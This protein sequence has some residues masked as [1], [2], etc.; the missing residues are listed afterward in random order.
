MK[1]MNVRMT[2]ALM[3]AMTMILGAAVLP[4]PAHA[5]VELNCIYGGLV[6]CNTEPGSWLRQLLSRFSFA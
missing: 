2:S 4:G 5:S 3:L 6:P 1:S